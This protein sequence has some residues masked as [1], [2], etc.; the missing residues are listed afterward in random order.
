MYFGI[1]V[2]SFKYFEVARGSFGFGLTTQIIQYLFIFCLILVCGLCKRR[3]KLVN[4][5]FL[6]QNLHN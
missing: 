1:R 2:K 5:E 6:L 3:V 4:V